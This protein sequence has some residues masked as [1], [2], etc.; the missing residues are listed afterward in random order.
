M[1]II[2]RVRR[3]DGD[4]DGDGSGALRA[5]GCGK[6]RRLRAIEA[7]AGEGSLVDLFREDNDAIM[8]RV[9]VGRVR[10]AQ[11][12]RKHGEARW[13]DSVCGRR[14]IGWRWGVDGG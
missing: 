7:G 14:V 2:A 13:Q 10:A 4:S 6:L 8:A 1:T 9:E 11:E 5:G 12:W 3:S